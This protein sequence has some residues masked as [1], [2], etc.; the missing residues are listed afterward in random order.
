MFTGVSNRGT[1]NFNNNNFVDL[2]AINIKNPIHSLFQALDN[3]DEQALL[4]F[5]DE[6]LEKPG[7]D[8][9]EL[10]EYF[11]KLLQ[12]LLER[13]LSQEAA[14][15]SAVILRKMAYRVFIKNPKCLAERA[16][17]ILDCLDGMSQWN[18]KTPH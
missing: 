16:G 4:N 18:K 5:P 9:Q 3:G 7:F 6:I 12:F 15:R 2:T 11:P 10:M 13:I 17:I 1:V 8:H 14:Y